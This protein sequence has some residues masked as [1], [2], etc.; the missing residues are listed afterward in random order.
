MQD[1][2]QSFSIYILEQIFWFNE[3]FYFMSLELLTLVILAQ[4]KI[5]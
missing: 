4:I 2:C 3:N 5:Y 1:F